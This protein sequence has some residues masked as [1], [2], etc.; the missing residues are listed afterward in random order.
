[1]TGLPRL[2]NT[3]AFN[4]SFSTCKNSSFYSNDQVCEEINLVVRVNV[5]QHRA[6]L[7][8]HARVD[9]RRATDASPASSRLNCMKTLFQISM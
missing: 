6:P 2:A 3:A 1:V 9:A 7:E 8:A 5:L 4:V